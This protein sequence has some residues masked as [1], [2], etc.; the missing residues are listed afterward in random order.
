M[1]NT[2]EKEVREVHAGQIICGHVCEFGFYCEYRKPLEKFE[3]G[4]VLLGQITLFK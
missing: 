3:Q 1:G 2:L 4:N